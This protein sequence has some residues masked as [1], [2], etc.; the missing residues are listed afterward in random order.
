MVSLYP[1]NVQ[2]DRNDCIVEI[3]IKARGDIQISKEQSPVKGL[4]LIN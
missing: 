1:I 2:I 4:E 3:N